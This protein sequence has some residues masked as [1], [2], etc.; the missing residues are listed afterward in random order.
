MRDIGEIHRRID[1]LEYYTSLSLLEQNT[2]NL[3]IANEAGEDRFKM[4]F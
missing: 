4:V 3:L 2:A 1:R